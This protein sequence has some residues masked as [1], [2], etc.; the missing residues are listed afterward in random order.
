M[1]IISWALWG[2]FAGAIARFLLPG[3]QTIGILG[4][5]VVGL[6]GALVG[7]FIATHVL[8]IADDS[9]FDFGSFLIAVAGAVVLL[10]IWEPIARRREDRQDTPA[11]PP[12]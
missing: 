9:N 2:L 10:A 8:H 5:M 3:R 6:V 1:G 12:V 4:T 11:S 7:G